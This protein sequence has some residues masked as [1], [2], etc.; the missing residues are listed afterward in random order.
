MRLKSAA[1]FAVC[2]LLVSF[3]LHGSAR[4][5][6]SV[7]PPLS[8]AAPQS[9]TDQGSPPAARR[10]HWSG[11]NWWCSSPPKDS[12][13]MVPE[14]P[15]YSA[16]RRPCY[17]TTG[18]RQRLATPSHPKRISAGGDRRRSR[19]NNDR[20]RF[21]A[22]GHQ[23]RISADGDRRRSSANSDRQ[24]LAAPSHQKRISAGGDR[25]RSS[26][27]NDR[28]RFAANS[29]QKRISADGDRRRSSANSDRQR[30]AALSHQKRISAGG[31]RRR[32]SA[33]NDRQRFAAKGHQKRISADGDR[34]R[35][36]ANSD[37]QRLAALSHQKRISARWRPTTFQREQRPP[38]V[39]HDWQQPRTRHR[40]R[41]RKTRG[42][43]L[44]TT[45]C[46]RRASA[47]G[48]RHR[49]P[50]PMA[51]SQLSTTTRRQV[52][53]CPLG[54]AQQNSPKSGKSQIFRGSLGRRRGS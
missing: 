43:R 38:K 44:S 30:L 40:Q 9:V 46:P 11:L 23:K 1:L 26:A 39:R 5:Q 10:C 42:H 21:A 47:S 33:N 32:S 36:S 31:D 34:R 52:S 28:Q 41:M 35:S 17:A 4:C 20:Q 12:P 48:L 37:R 54:L 27:N 50:V 7:V 2:F 22:K 24:R 25:R 16:A 19:A 8:L 51:S 53:R 18:D 3:W 13:P 49:S 6:S 15:M 14:V 29:D 45:F